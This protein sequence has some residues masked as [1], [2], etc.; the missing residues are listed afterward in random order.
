MAGLLAFLSVVGQALVLTVGY[1][2]CV[3]ALAAFFDW[4]ERRSR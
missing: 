1:V 2:A 3:A 4:A